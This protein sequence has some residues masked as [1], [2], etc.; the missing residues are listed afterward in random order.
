MQRPVGI[1]AGAIGVVGPGGVRDA[2]VE[3][4][5]GVVA[6]V[7][8]VPGGVRI[9]SAGADLDVGLERVTAVGAEGAPEPGVV[10]RQ[11][12][13]VAGA[14]RSEVVAGVIPDDGDLSAGRVARDLRQEL[15][16]HG[17]VVV[18]ALGP[19]PAR[20]VVVRVAD[21]DVRVVALVLLLERVD[22]IDTAVV[23]PARPVPGKAGLSIDGAVGLRRDEVEAPNMGGGDEDAVAEAGRP[24]PIGVDVDEELATAL[25]ALGQGADLHHLSRRTDR[26]VA[27]GAV[28]R[29]RY[30]LA[31]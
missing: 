10:V 2:A 22:E 15:A 24:E 9:R 12:V 5:A 20:A 27:V 17:R 16:V 19:A 6:V 30:Y 11:A 1:G 21:V 8:R 28:V 26:A 29:P 7:D 18:D 25:A 23:R 31:G 4:Q 3:G 13:R 14:A